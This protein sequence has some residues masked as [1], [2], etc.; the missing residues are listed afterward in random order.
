VVKDLG[1]ESRGTICDKSLQMFAYADDIVILGRTT[2]VLKE[3]ITNLSKA[4]KE[5]G[6]TMKL[7]NN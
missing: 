4:T 7:Q 2:S 1:L 5:I 6:L 3:V